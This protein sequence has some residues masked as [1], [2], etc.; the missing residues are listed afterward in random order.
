MDRSVE[1]LCERLRAAKR[2]EDVFGAITDGSLAD[3]LAAVKR[4]FNGFVVLV[5]PDKNPDM[6]DAGTHVA[7]LVKLR[8]EAEKFIKDG[9]YGKPRKAAV[10]AALRS[11][12][13]TYKVIEEFRAGEVADLF[14]GELDG[15]RCLLKIVRQPSDNDLLDNEAWVLGELHAKTGER[16]RVFRKYLPKILDTFSLI[17][18]GGRQRRVNVLDI[19]EPEAEYVRRLLAKKG[20][21]ASKDY[22]SLAEIREAYPEGLETAD[23]AWMIRRA[24]EGLG[25]VHSVGYVH[26]AVLPEHV[27]VHPT[28]HG[29][30]LVGW[31]YAVRAG[32]RLTAISASRKGMYPPGVFRRERA[33]PVL[34]IQLAGECAALLLSDRNGKLRSD[35][36]PGVAKFFAD[37]REGR[38]RDGW[39]AYRTYDGVLKRHFGARTYRA[40]A[41]P[42]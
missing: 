35:V 37:C 24:F 18:S 3:R 15:K 31:S 25:W 10:D 23:A 19:A 42:R 7:R 11:K 34:D 41:M 30:R 1:I 13:G 4:L 28:E 33:K 22:F 9:T 32:A 36:P 2:P 14:I 38:V 17:E 12:K 27:I 39:E 40:F 6:P 21:T 16:A 29:A 20:V 8:A 5:H 26:G